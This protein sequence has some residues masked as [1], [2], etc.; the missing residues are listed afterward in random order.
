VYTVVTLEMYWRLRYRGACGW[1]KYS[2]ILMEKF[3]SSWTLPPMTGIRLN[4]PVV[5][6]VIGV[7]GGIVPSNIGPVHCY[8]LLAFG[9]PA[10]W[11]I[12]AADNAARQAAAPGEAS[13]DN[14]QP[15]QTPAREQSYRAD[16][17]TGQWRAF[18]NRTVEQSSAQLEI[19]LTPVSWRTGDARRA[20][21]DWDRRRRGRAMLRCTQRNTA[22]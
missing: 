21:P 1:A 11:R 5:Q 3:C 18:I 19:W 22:C 6:A 12:S 7:I 4:L 20:R 13:V 9:V 14:R 2:A 8:A 16:R 15:V 17:D 10:N